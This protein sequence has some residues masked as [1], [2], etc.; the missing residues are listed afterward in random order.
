M[1]SK[2]AWLS[3]HE[4]QQR[5]VSRLNRLHKRWLWCDL[6]IGG[7]F[8]LKSNC[9]WKSVFLLLHR[10]KRTNYCNLRYKL[11]KLKNNM[12]LPFF[13]NETIKRLLSLNWS[14]YLLGLKYDTTEAAPLTII[15]PSN[16]LLFKV[17]PYLL[18]RAL[19][20]IHISTSWSN[21]AVD[22]Y[23]PIQH[24]YSFHRQ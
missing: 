22:R 10:Q 4:T 17:K 15:L 8:N 1:E 3:W 13:V 16:M 7:K 5:P 19:R 2:E 24:R 23:I 18:K 20:L 21:N 14:L 11:Y 9:K 6:W 12:H